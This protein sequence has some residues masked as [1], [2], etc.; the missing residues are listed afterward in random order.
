MDN[1]KFQVPVDKLRWRCDPESYKFQ[2]T[3]EL[4][5]L[6]EF[7]GQDRDIRSINF[8]LGMEKKGYNIFVTGLTGTGKASAIKAHLEKMVAW[9]KDVEDDVRDWCYIHNF[10]D[11]DKPR[12]LSLSKGKGK[13][14]ERALE[15]LLQDLKD[16]VS[17]AFS[18]DDYEEQR[19][20]VTEQSQSQRYQVIKQ[21]EAEVNK[22]GFTVQPSPAGI[23]LI[24]VVEGRPIAQREYVSLPEEQRK[25]LEAKQRDLSKLVNERLERIRNLEKEIGDVLKDLDQKVAEYATIQPFNRINEE[26]KEFP[27]ILKFLE[28]IKDYTVSRI[29]LFRQVDAQVP[30]P[31][32]IAL[33]GVQIPGAPRERDPYLPFRVNVF[34]DN[35][36]TAGPPIIG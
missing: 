36:Y 31:Q 10:A 23:I 1:S 32:A 29:D 3:D 21:L 30:A 26:H 8:G 17:Q 9:K 20:N 33:P 4:V 22:E 28:E 15:R 35:K 34:V 24:P 19:K 27:E 11:S 5:P 25:S 13:T 2:C 16:A 6:E 7:I 14:F 18:G 12:A